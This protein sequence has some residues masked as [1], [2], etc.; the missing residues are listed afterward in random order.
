MF[1]IPRPETT[2]SQ[3]TRPFSVERRYSS[4]A[5]SRL[6]RAANRNVRLGRNRTVLLPSQISSASPRPVPA[7]I[8]PACP[9]ASG[10]PACSVKIL[11]GASSG[12]PKPFASRSLIREICGI[13]SDLTRSR[14]SSVQGRL[15]NFRRPSRTGPGKPK[16]AAI[17]SLVWPRRCRRPRQETYSPP[18]R[19]WRTRAP[20]TSGRDRLKASFSKVV[21]R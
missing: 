7:A 8:N 17:M 9:S 13:E 20:E 4:S 12:M 1:L 6:L 10:L 2:R 14:V 19:D 11:S 5:I 21:Q 18:H 15:V 16:Q 3:L